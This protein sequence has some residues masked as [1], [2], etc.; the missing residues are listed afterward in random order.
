MLY[1]VLTDK[2]LLDLF[3]MNELIVS[4]AIHFSFY[5][6]YSNVPHFYNSENVLQLGNQRYLDPRFL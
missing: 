1:S 2:N 4:S 5:R 3:L 6:R